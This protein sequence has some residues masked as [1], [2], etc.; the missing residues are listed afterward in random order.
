[1]EDQ[2]SDQEQEIV[3]PAKPKGRGKKK[4]KSNPFD[5]LDLDDISG[6]G[7]SFYYIE[8]ASLAQSM[9]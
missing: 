7:E 2:G 8:V 1:M 4:A 5:E 9:V 3:S 6:E